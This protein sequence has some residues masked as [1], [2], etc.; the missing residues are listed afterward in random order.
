M[1]KYDNVMIKERGTGKKEH[2]EYDFCN[3][4]QIENQ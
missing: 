3:L 1:Y 2:K 4:F